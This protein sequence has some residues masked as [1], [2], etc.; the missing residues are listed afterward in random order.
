MWPEVIRLT[1]KYSVTSGHIALVKINTFGYI[2]GT[3]YVQNICKICVQYPAIT[4]ISGVGLM[5]KNGDISGIDATQIQMQ[6][7]KSQI[8]I[9]LL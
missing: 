8:T 3:W 5:R 9:K 4:R 2:S 6:N 7:P 1:R